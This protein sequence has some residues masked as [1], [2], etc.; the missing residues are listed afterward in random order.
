M[1]MIMSIRWD[2]TWLLYVVFWWYDRCVQG[3]CF[4]V[5]LLYLSVIIYNILTL[6]MQS[7]LLFSKGKTNT[8][9]KAVSLTTPRDLISLGVSESLQ[10]WM[11]MHT[12]RCCMCGCMAYM[13]ILCVHNI[14]CAYLSMCSACRN[15]SPRVYVCVFLC[16]VF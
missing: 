9:I 5:L 4:T 2:I 8:E 15:I 3:K 7:T 10:I 6:Y 11:C 12:C 16:E 1:S 14:V 13:C